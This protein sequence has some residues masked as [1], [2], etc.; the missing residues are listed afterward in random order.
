[1][2]LLEKAKANYKKWHQ[3]DPKSVD[4]NSYDFPAKVFYCGAVEYMIYES[5]KWEDDGDFH[6]YEHDF[7]SSPPIYA[8]RSAR[9]LTPSKHRFRRTPRLLCVD[10]EMGEVPLTMLACVL[11]M[12]VKTPSKKQKFVF[13]EPPVMAGTP[14]NKTL[15]IF[16]DAGPLFISGGRMRITERGIV[17]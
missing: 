5:D 12:V 11:E 1:M 3:K 9:I 2:S 10:D 7:D 8:P 17:Y 15:V 16:S 13:S 14:D 6:W 4:D